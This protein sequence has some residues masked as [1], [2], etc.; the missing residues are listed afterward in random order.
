MKLF[1]GCMRNRVNFFLPLITISG[2]PAAAWKMIR[3]VIFNNILYHARLPKESGIAFKAGYY[4]I[5]VR[6]MVKIS[7]GMTKS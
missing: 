1:Q 4:H 2:N 5:I 6:P 7:K 3:S